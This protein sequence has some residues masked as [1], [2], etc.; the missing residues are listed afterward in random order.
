MQRPVYRL[1]IPRG[2]AVLG[3]ESEP[4]EIQAQLCREPGGAAQISGWVLH[5]RRA[6]RIALAYAINRNAMRAAGA[7]A[8]ASVRSPIIR[9]GSSNAQASAATIGPS[10]PA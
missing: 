5:G 10:G 7:A 3:V 6:G 4:D 1:T 2:M 8:P 9:H